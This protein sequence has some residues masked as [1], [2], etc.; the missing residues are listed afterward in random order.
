MLSSNTKFVSTHIRLTAHINA[1]SGAYTMA[2]GPN[3]TGCLTS[4]GLHTCLPSCPPGPDSPSV[5]KLTD[6]LRLLETERDE[7]V[8][9]GE[10]CARTA[11]KLEEMV[12]S[13]AVGEEGP[14]RA[15]QFC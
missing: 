3:L 11:V 14:S 7:A 6:D 5:S 8:R 4:T 2:P 9:V 1:S 12:S 15:A 13:T 10:E